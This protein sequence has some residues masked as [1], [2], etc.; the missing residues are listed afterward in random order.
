[1]AFLH[2]KVA[3]YSTLSQAGGFIELLLFIVIV[4]SIFNKIFFLHFQEGNHFRALQF[5]LCSF[6]AC[7]GWQYSRCRTHIIPPLWLPL[8]VLSFWKSFGCQSKMAFL[9]TN[10]PRAV[11][12]TAAN[13]LVLVCHLYIKHGPE[14]KSLQQCDQRSLFK[15]LFNTQ[16]PVKCI[17]LAAL[18]SD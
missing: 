13:T 10:E 4:Q 16:R 18:N 6:P 11:K 14:S 15:S 5:V 9:V 12:H 1:M 3:P 7:R 17:I 2:V 8:P